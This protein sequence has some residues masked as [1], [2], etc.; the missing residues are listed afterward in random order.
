[1]YIFYPEEVK[2]PILL[3]LPHDNGNVTQH[4]KKRIK[5]E[6]IPS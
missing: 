1:M 3:S 5:T 2:T 6:F 4:A